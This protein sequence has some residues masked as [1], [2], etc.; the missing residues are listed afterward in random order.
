MKKQ[1]QLFKQTRWRLITG[2]AG[3]LSVIL[4]VCG[5]GFYE[6]VAHAHR[7]TINQELK[8]ISENLRDSLKP[9]LKWPGKLDQEVINF[10]PD[11]CFTENP[12]LQVPNHHH[13]LSEDIESE[14]YY[15]YFFN[16]S[17]NLIAI[18]GIKTDQ[19]LFNDHLEKWQDI[20][21]IN[22]IRYRQITLK[23]YTNQNQPWGYLQVGRNLQD[24]DHYVH[25]IKWIIL[26][27][28]P[29]IILLVMISSW[30][31]AGRAMQPIYQSYHQIQQFTADAAHELRTPLAAIRATVESTLMLPN[32]TEKESRET[33]KTI[34]RQNQRLCNLVADL[35][36]LCRIDQQLTIKAPIQQ[37]VEIVCLND[38]VNDLIEEFSA[39]AKNSEIN[40]TAI[41]PPNQNLYVIGNEEQLYRLV[42]NLVINGIQY[43]QPKGQVTIVLK[44]K[45]DKGLISVID[46]GI[47]ISEIDKKLIF[48]R[49]YQVNKARSRD[50][51]GSGLGLSIAQAIAMAH[52]GSIEVKTEMNQGSIFTIYLPLL[53][54]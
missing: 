13:G 15:I 4:A 19:I 27:G 36:M 8:T 26:L 16:L 3:I 37:E 45:N 30:W 17:E 9:I 7:I 29:M 31:L 5:I 54:S 42:A 51:S 23:L 53:R 18:S 20:T 52:Q 41:L 32:L 48:D 2:Y 12:C 50:Q 43:T 38:L 10:L 49:F 47:G 35:L 21:D 46:T 1:N 22:G 14:K 6:A 40:L 28:L 33:L 39:L 25:N 24:F 44:Q 34:Q 11:L